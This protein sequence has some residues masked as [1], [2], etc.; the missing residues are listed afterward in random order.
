VLAPDVPVR[1]G[2]T[3]DGWY[4]D[5]AGTV[6]WD[7]GN[8]T[9]KEDITLY[10]TWTRNTYTVT[11][12]TGNVTPTPATL[13]AVPYDDKITDPGVTKTGFT[14]DG[15]Y[16][17]TA[18]TTKWDFVTDTVKES[19]T[20]YGTWTRNSYTV[21]FSLNRAPGTAP[22]H[23][24]VLYE[25]KIT[26]PDPAPEQEGYTLD[27]WYKEAACTNPWN[28]GTDTVT[29]NITLYAKWKPITLAAFIAEM[30]N[31]AGTTAKTYTLPSGNNE[32][33]TGTVTLTTANSPT[34]VTIDGSNRVITGSAN[35][36]TIGAG[37]TITLKNITFKTLPLTVAAGGTLVLDNGAVVT[38]NAGTGVTV[39]GTSA[40]AK[41]TLELKAGAL[42]TQNLASGIV[43]ENNSVL[44]MTGGEIS[45]NTT[46][47]D[48]G[49]VLVKGANSVFTMN[50]G[51]IKDNEAPLFWSNPAR[52]GGGVAV[53]DGAKFTMT[54][55]T[56]SANKAY[57]GAG[58]AMSSDGGTFT[59]SGGKI[60]GN[61][62]NYGSGVL[63]GKDGGVFNM[64]GTAEISGNNANYGGGVYLW[65]PANIIF[66]MSGG[67]IKN[68]DAKYSGGGVDASGT[69]NMSGGKIT[70]NRSHDEGGGVNFRGTF[71]MTGG[72]IASNTADYNGGGVYKMPNSFLTGDPQ[73]G[74]NNPGAGKGWIHGNTATNNPE[75]NE[76]N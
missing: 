43:L 38:E 58:A 5:A 1:T 59:M 41:G 69:F 26:L 4:T 11:F 17:E 34:S 49:G 14:F 35:R 72:E 76:T 20:L 40:T 2:F 30:A 60:S 37:V 19:I 31:D 23:P 42:V 13:P 29:A 7:F 24:A 55:G 36:I 25:D 8:D 53:V 64:S 10:G 44:T 74:G 18:K 32:T 16:T 9:I 71:H 57:W 39:T 65:T 52:Y 27:G 21:T 3:F 47:G 56:I 6:K 50:G 63:I 68:N 54:D 22:T 51:S 61:N 73:I 67:V 12:N 70:D 45:G 66:N 15:W 48:G 33:Y 28:F 62:A 75:T 46:V